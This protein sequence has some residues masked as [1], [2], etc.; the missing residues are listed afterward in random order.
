MRALWLEGG[1]LRL[2]EDVPVPELVSGEALV[3]VIVAGICNTDLELARGYYPFSGIPGHEFVGRVERGPPH[4][5][6]KRVV[7][8]IN[9]SCGS[10]QLCRDGHGNHCPNRTFV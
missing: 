6:G 10:C 1:D 3:K 9:A 5:L 8:E 4:L 2:R 7:G